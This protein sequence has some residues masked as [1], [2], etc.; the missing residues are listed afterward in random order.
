MST[1]TWRHGTPTGYSQHQAVDEQ[2]CDACY[3]AKSAY[4]K[5][6]REGSEQLQRNRLSAQA[7]QM[8]YRRLAHA[9][10]AIYAALYAEEKAKRGLVARPPRRTQTE[11]VHGTFS[12]YQKERKRGITPCAD[13][14]RAF[15]AHQKALREQG[16]S[17]A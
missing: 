13:C 2:P 15:A 4:D 10:P 3:A 14:R 9:H 12:G 6:W 7:Q 11:I 17:A 8:A 1:K 16:A 5:R